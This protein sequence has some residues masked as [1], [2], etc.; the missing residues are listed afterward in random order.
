MRQKR[1]L[2][3]TKKID[4]AFFFGYKKWEEQFPE[5]AKRWQ[6]V[7]LIEGHPTY[8]AFR[9][10]ALYH[11]W[12]G[13]DS[14]EFPDI[15]TKFMMDNGDPYGRHIREMTG[16]YEGGLFA[17]ILLAL[18]GREPDYRDRM[19]LLQQLFEGRTFVRDL[20]DAVLKDRVIEGVEELNNLYKESVDAYINDIAANSLFVGAR[21]T[22][23]FSAAGDFI[24]FKFNDEEINLI[25]ELEE[26]NLNAAGEVFRLTD[27]PY[28]VRQENSI[29][30]VPLEKE[31]I[32]SLTDKRIQFKPSGE[33]TLIDVE[34]SEVE[35]ESGPSYLMLH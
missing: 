25:T 27:E 17:G 12:D 28:V 33:G 30:V 23:A 22:G 1:W 13:N 26:A 3:E 35:P 2:N 15:L 5:A 14:S 4:Q 19:S 34:Y 16:S 11:E 20:E 9:S 10:F 31:R 8:A 24:A 18:L 7:D 6:P 21:T 29:M 32:I